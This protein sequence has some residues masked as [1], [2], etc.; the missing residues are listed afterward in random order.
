[1]NRKKSQNVWEAGLAIKNPTNKTKKK[2]KKPPQSG[3]FGFY[4]VL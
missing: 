4:W 1:M 2:P 3:V